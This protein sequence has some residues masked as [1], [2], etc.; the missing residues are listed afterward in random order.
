M[1]RNVRV[2]TGPRPTGEIERAQEFAD[3]LMA[4]SLR[5]R[6]PEQRGPVQVTMSP[7]EG[8][9][10]L[11]EAAIG[12]SSQK[13]AR[14]LAEAEQERLRA[15][16]E[17]LVGQLGG[18]KDAPRRI[19]DRAPMANFG[20]PTG[21]P[22]D[23]P[24]DMR[25]PTDKAE[26][27]A[28]AIAGMD[29]G[30]ANSALSG[31]S[32]QRLLA[33]PEAEEAYTLT[34]GSA[35][36]KGDRMITERPAEAK[37]P[38]LP[39]GMRMNPQTGQPEWI[40]GY[41]EAKERLAAAGRSSTNI[42][43]DPDGSNRYGAPPPGYY[44]PDPSQPNVAQM[45][46]GPAALESQQTREKDQA[47][48]ESQ[49]IKAQGVIGEIDKALGIVSPRT[50]G[51]MGAATRNMAPFEGAGTDARTLAAT[52]ETIQANLGF[53]EL[54]KMRQESPTGGALG[55]V[56][57]QELV[58]LRATVA[59]L[60]PNLPADVLKKNLEKVKTHYGR[61][62]MTT[63]GQMPP[64]LEAA[65]GQA[66]GVGQFGLPPADEALIGQFLNQGQ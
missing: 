66:P 61:W 39:E 52:V 30:A 31:V 14:K 44:R 45:P 47:R 58:A 50:A 17:Q 24:E 21:A 32:L 7:W 60:D 54:A 13:Y 35:R 36:Y 11:G 22:I 28:A 64:P 33:D 59:N 12:A 48:R 19:E 1:A 62:L 40:P 53:D 55:P 8:I 42:T 51:L 10:Q 18:Y 3:A 37:Q 2:V 43:Y 4:R 57:V 26:K 29:P 15:A 56:A 41:L 5:P 49:T 23:L 38:G 25:V 16:N 34:P 20:Q 63:Q 65:G 9:A 27:L 46:G 6:G